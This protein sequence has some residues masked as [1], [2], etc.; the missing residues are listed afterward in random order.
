MKKKTNDIK[1]TFSIGEDVANIL[2][3]AALTHI[4][5]GIKEGQSSTTLVAEVHTEIETIAYNSKV[6]LEQLLAE[7]IRQVRD[8]EV[9]VSTDEAKDSDGLPS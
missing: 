3:Y 2:A 1:E 7:R 6:R 9:D 5:T 4:L 8:G